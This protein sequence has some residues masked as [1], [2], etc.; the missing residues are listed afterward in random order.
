[1]NI[2][3]LSYCVSREE[4]NDTS[5]KISASAISFFGLCLLI[6][7]LHLTALGWRCRK[8]YVGVWLC[9]HHRTS[10]RIPEDFLLSGSQKQASRPWASLCWFVLKHCYFRLLGLLPGER[11]QTGVHILLG[12]LGSRCF[13][14]SPPIRKC[15]RGRVGPS[16]PEAFTELHLSNH[17]S[18]PLLPYH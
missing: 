10:V 1:M 9:R 8:L 12:R 16:V 6:S 4:N 5:R 2:S 11:R 17:F 18:D 7:S 14:M 13:S 3:F 15:I